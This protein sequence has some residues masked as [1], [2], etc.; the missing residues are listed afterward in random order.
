MTSPKGS[1]KRRRFTPKA[2]MSIAIIAVF[3][4]SMA[5]VYFNQGASNIVG[6]VSVAREEVFYQFV[7]SDTQQVD[8][9]YVVNY[10]IEVFES[11]TTM[12]MIDK[13]PPN[14]TQIMVDQDS[15]NVQVSYNPTSGE[16]RVTAT[17][18]VKGQSYMAQLD[19]QYPQ[20]QMFDGSAPTITVS[21]VPT[22]GYRGNLTINMSAFK[23]NHA[24]QLYETNVYLWFNEL[25]TNK[26]ILSSFPPALAQKPAWEA[27]WLYNNNATASF[28]PRTVTY[29]VTVGDSS[30]GKYLL[31]GWIEMH[32]TQSVIMKGETATFQGVKDSYLRDAGCGYTWE[33]DYAIS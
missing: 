2:V 3:I 7:Q 13:G 28:D 11:S 26:T 17:N 1:R 15:P 18:V 16:I 5:V 6:K 30:F 33:Y 32:S 14:L 12:T 20:Q 29:N 9:R 27:M 24:D 22:Y 8:S 25:A 23:L 4:L 19:F 31:R 21:P 10:A